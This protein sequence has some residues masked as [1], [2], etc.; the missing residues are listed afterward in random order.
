MIEIIII[1]IISFIIFTI[2]PL[3][4]DY[5]HKVDILVEDIVSYIKV[6]LL[7]PFAL[8]YYLYIYIRYTYNRIRFNT[9]IKGNSE[10]KYFRRKILS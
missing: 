8:F 1:W 9:V 10:N 7:G 4:I 2:L 6:G 3:L 5:K